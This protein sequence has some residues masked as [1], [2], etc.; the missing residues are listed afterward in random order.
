MGRPKHHDARTAAALLEAAEQVA[1]TQGLAAVSVRGIADQVQTTTRAIY[2]LFGSKEGLIAALGART[3]DLLAATVQALPVTEDAAADLVAAGVR[4]FRALTLEH[5]ALFQLGV[6]Q[7]SATPDQARQIGASAARAWVVLQARVLRLQD[8]VGLG[9]H[10]V[11]E[12]ATGFHALCEGLAALETRELLPATQA[13][14]IWSSAL[15]ALIAGYCSEQ[16]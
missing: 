4:G 14:P 2:S 11:D 8:Q 7:L 15:T 3:W 5:P 13:E 10:S 9:R 6:L 16:S 1:A 12:V